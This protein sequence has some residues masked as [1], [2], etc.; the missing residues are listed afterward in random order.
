MDRYDG[1]PTKEKIKVLVVDDHPLLRLGVVSMIKQQRDMTV[2]GQAGSVAEAIVQYNKTRPEVVLM[3]LRLPDGSGVD[4]IKKIKAADN[5]VRICVLTTYEGDEDI[6][7]ALEAGAQS[8]LIKGMQH[9]VLIRAIRKVHG[10]QRF[11][12]PL[13]TDALSGRIASLALTDRE[14]QVLQGVFEGKSNREIAEK[15]GIGETTVK[16]HVSVVLT[17]LNVED[18]TQAVVEALKKG[19]LHI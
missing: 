4:A 1:E 8:Y 9:D 19:L 3:D 6:H 18:R 12:P 2:V 16:T 13:V 15:L 7:R 10:G 17:K 5:A 11:L 14:R